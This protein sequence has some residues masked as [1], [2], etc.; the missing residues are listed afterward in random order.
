MKK[1]GSVLVWNVLCGA[2]MSTG[3][4]P[5]QGKLISHFGL[6]WMPLVPGAL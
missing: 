2:F 5:E 1:R 6:L 4:K 3:I